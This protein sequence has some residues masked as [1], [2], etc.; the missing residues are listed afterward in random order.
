M[1][2]LTVSGNNVGDEIKMKRGG[3][4]LEALA[5][6]QSVWPVHV[7]DLIVNGQVVDSVQ[8][9]KGHKNLSLKTKIKIDGTAWIAARTASKFEKHQVMMGSGYLGAHTSPI[10]VK[11]ADSE[12]FSPSDAIYMLTLLEGTLAYLDTLGTRLSEK[13]HG[14]MMSIVQ[15]AHHTLQSRL[16]HHHGSGGHTH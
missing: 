10:Y 12:L 6:V 9:A 7:L 15:A 4:T 16:D 8:A 14:Q 3:G 5:T 11:M 13:R 2:D 1:I